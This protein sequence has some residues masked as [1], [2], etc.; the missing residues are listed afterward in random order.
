MRRLLRPGR[1]R[2]GLVG[3]EVRIDVE[4]RVLGNGLR[5]LVAPRRHT[6]VAALHAVVDGGQR[7]ERKPGAAS[8][9]GAAL[10]AGAGERT[11][12]QVVD[13]VE[14][15]GASLSTHG[16]GLS[17]R[18]RASDLPLGI[19][20]AAD[21]LRRPRFDPGAVDRERD[22]AVSELAAERDHPTAVGM[23]ALSAAI[24]GPHPF[25]RH[26][27]GDPMQLSRD[28]LVAYHAEFF[29]PQTAVVALAGAVD[30]AE[31]MRLVED[32]FAGWPAGPS[33]ALPLP[34]APPPPSSSEARVPH[35]GEQLH[36]FLGHIGVP[37]RHPD[38]AALRV[39]E[40]ILGSG[41]GLTDRLSTRIRDELGLAYAVSADI[42]AT[43]GAEPGLF[44]AHVGTSP[45]HAA[46]ARAEVV[47]AM[48]EMMGGVPGEEEISG[49]KAYLASEWVF[50]LETADRTAAIL[51]TIERLGL[52]LDYPERHLAA[53]AAT[54]P[55]EV[56]AVA[57]RHLHPDRLAVVAVGPDR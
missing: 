10:F 39:M 35:E 19:S 46:R 36:L 44:R 17:M 29:R 55:E 25:A 53:I 5:V 21:L 15:A 18:L 47:R 23:R 34:A 54:G 26:P 16:S 1:R 31:A 22:L 38:F 12:E 20:I 6:P 2:H 30:V 8:L 57:R 4:R 41:G 49:V 43:A 27:R 24:Y 52:G 14:F 42:C 28:D 37:L 45:R 3:A 51:A 32:A 50:E 7:R 40:S 9:A 56:R 33:S 13:D 11:E 48:R